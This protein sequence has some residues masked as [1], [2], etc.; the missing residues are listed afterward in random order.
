MP[1]PARAMRLPE[2]LTGAA[3]RKGRELG[4]RTLTDC[5]A[6][7]L[8]E[9]TGTGEPAALGLAAAR[10]EA[11]SASAR[12]ERTEREL[13]SVRAELAKLKSAVARS[14]DLT[15]QED[16]FIQALKAASPA[17]PVATA[18]LITV[19]GWSYRW[20]R[21]LLATLVSEGV[22]TRVTKGWYA[23]VPGADLREGVR[24]AKGHAVRATARIGPR[25]RAGGDLAD[26]G[27]PE[28]GSPAPAVFMEAGQ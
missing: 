26:R 27:K 6:A 16:R 22:I 21:S 4:L 17:S 11:A 20:V 25:Y 10:E 19:S 18:R 8:S 5:V 12:A 2:D 7:A 1:T 15:W 28:A 24:I 13:S 14:A 23:P 9:W 3:Q